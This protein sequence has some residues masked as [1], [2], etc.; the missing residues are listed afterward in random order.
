M[1][2]VE[3]ATTIIKAA[4]GAALDVCD[5]HETAGCKS[6][7]GYPVPGCSHCF[8]SDW[9]MGR[10]AASIRVMKSCGFTPR[11][12]RAKLSYYRESAPFVIEKIRKG[13]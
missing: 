2:S 1:N 5:H 7:G 6:H 13:T 12:L 10:I 3:A 4:K 9:A 11:Q 8:L